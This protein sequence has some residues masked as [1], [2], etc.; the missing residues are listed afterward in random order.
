MT[1]HISAGMEDTLEYYKEQANLHRE[2]LASLR[3]EVRRMKRSVQEHLEMNLEEIGKAH[4]HAIADILGITITRTVD[5]EVNVT[6]TFKV[7]LELGEEFDEDDFYFEADSYDKHVEDHSYT[8]IW[9]T[10]EEES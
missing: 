10:V 2:A 5:V 8:I 7:N 9:K 3:D 4:A 6:H 1:T